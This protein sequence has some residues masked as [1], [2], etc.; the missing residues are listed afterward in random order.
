MYG[1]QHFPQEVIDRIA[2]RIAQMQ[3]TLELAGCRLALVRQA[4]HALV[5]EF[6]TPGMPE[7]E[8]VDKYL[9]INYAEV[10]PSSV[11]TVVSCEDFDEA[12]YFLDRVEERLGP[13][14]VVDYAAVVKAANGI[15]WDAYADEAYN[16]TDD[17]S[18]SSLPCNDAPRPYWWDVDGFRNAEL[19][20]TA[21]WTTT[22]AYV[23][24]P[25]PDGGIGIL[26]D[27]QSTGLG[28]E[29]EYDFDLNTFEERYG[30]AVG[31]LE[32]FLLLKLLCW[33]GRVKH[34]FL[35]PNQGSY[36]MD[37]NRAHVEG[38]KY[39][40]IRYDWIAGLWLTPV[41]ENVRYFEKGIK[42]DQFTYLYSDYSPDGTQS[43][44]DRMI[45]AWL[46]EAREDAVEK[47]DKE[48]IS[49]IDRLRL[50]YQQPSIQEKEATP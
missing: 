41:A 46:L 50:K 36:Q 29:H 5:F 27:T 19:V 16:F 43:D 2:Q 26:I 21:N 4:W 44:F 22:C 35:E 40:F 18:P 15:I 10:M 17:W 6:I 38:P 3:P 12:N 45:F 48:A 33:R 49:S 14:A 28:G 1:E 42:N 20:C 30:F 8:P 34:E 7:V 24:I 47:E 32:E 25:E 9:S 11:P 39:A 37:D 23:D 31:S 13:E